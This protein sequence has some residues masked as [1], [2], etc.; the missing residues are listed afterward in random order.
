D[1]AEEKIDLSNDYWQWRLTA[2]CGHYVFDRSEVKEKRNLMMR[3]LRLL[4]PD[5]EEFVREKI[6]RCLRKYIRCFRLEN[7]LMN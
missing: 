2:I 5:P 6:R 3:N 4:Y 1:R 7:F